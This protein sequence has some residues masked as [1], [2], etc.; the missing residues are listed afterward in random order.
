MTILNF[1][2]QASLVLL[3]EI[4]TIIIIG[5]W[6]VCVYQVMD[7]CIMGAWLLSTLEAI[8]IVQLL[9]FFHA[10]QPSLCIYNSIDTG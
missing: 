1:S 7:A 6:L 9:G 10:W 8:T 5:S 4:E 3:L 2:D